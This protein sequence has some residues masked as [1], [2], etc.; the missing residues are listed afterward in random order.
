MAR[1]DGRGRADEAAS[2]ICFAAQRRL[3]EPR[4]GRSKAAVRPVCAC[5]VGGAGT[6]T[7]RL[8]SMRRPFTRR[9]LRTEC[10]EGSAS[11]PKPER[12]PGVR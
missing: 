9:A 2:L 4:D 10:L 3:F 1:Q 11:P 5:P 8:F 6:R 12:P 7:W